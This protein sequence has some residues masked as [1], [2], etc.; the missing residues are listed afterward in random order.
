MSLANDLVVIVTIAA[1]GAVMLL[2]AIIASKIGSEIFRKK[3]KKLLRKLKA[4]M[5]W[6]G[7]VNSFK[8][9]CFKHCITVGNQLKL[10]SKGSE[11]LNKK[12]LI[13]AGVLLVVYVCL[14]L[15]I[16]KFVWK[17]YLKLNFRWMTKKYG[18]LYYGI[19][20]KRD[21]LMVLRF[22]VTLAH[23]LVFVLIASLLYNHQSLQLQCLVFLSLAYSCF[24]FWFKPIA[25]HSEVVIERLTTG[26][27]HMSMI[28]VFLLSDFVTFQ[29]NLLYSLIYIGGMAIVFVLQMGFILGKSVIRFMRIRNIRKM[30][31]QKRKAEYEA[32]K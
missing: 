14:V 16:A 7:L 4:Q 28:C 2:I 32:L 15:I 8:I 17:N 3:L 9:S 26:F 24:I 22:P 5:V 27:V 30:K 13:G 20:I 12:E 29:E 21:K 6:S 10:A 31:E 1:V 19:S 18:N 11:F 25:S 23:R